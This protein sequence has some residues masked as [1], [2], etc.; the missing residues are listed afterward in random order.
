MS[1]VFD[2]KIALF[3]GAGPW[4]SAYAHSVL[5][6]QAQQDYGAVQDN[7][8]PEVLHVS[9]ALKGF[10]AKGIE[11]DGLIFQQIS[12]TFDLFKTW[13]AKL[14]V[15]C[16]NSL[17]RHAAGLNAVYPD[18][19]IVR[20]PESGAAELASLGL[21]RVGVF[22]SESALVDGL[23]KK[24]LKAFGLDAVLP[25]R[26]QQDR[27][28]AMIETVMAGDTTQV[29][30]GDYRRLTHAFRAAG[31]QAILSGC[32]ELSYLATKTQTPLPLVDCLDAAMTR[33]LKLAVKA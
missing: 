19:E 23:H 32:T 6:R 10:G 14:A 22:C 4:A 9:S 27:V 3:G 1:S 24:A 13:G 8:Y 25:D 7:Q 12:E 16:C 30:L 29:M 18:I 17:H 31:A 15:I 11:D 28:N 26:Q 21:K 33:T 2:K 20:L 5:V